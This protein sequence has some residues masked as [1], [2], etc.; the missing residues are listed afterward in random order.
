MWS[1]LNG[2]WLIYHSTCVRF[3]TLQRV[4]SP[5]FAA[6]G[7][8]NPANNCTIN[9]VDFLNVFDPSQNGKCN[10]TFDTTGKAVLAEVVS[11]TFNFLNGTLVQLDFSLT[12]TFPGCNI[13]DSSTS[14][15]ITCRVATP[16][17]N[18]L[19]WYS[20]KFVVKQTEQEYYNVFTPGFINGLPIQN[21][22]W[23]GVPYSTLGG[24][25]NANNSSPGVTDIETD[26]DK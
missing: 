2:I 22:L 26:D 21:K 4:F 15:T 20:Y 1:S 11:S 7:Q 13:N 5:T 24:S 18:T 19:G 12:V 16:V 25:G 14:G 3:K 9:N 17:D 8:W 10:V 23:N 6:N